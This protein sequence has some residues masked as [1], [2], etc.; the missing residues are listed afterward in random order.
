MR[1]EIFGQNILYAMLNFRLTLRK[2]HLFVGLGLT[3]MYLVYKQFG[4]V[5]MIVL[6]MSMKLVVNLLD[7]LFLYDAIIP[8]FLGRPKYKGDSGEIYI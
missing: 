3:W 5:L 7:R 1:F 4:L 8:N 2:L 6:G